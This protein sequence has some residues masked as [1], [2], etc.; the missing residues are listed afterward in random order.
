MWWIIAYAVQAGITIAICVREVAHPQR[1]LTWAVLNLLFPGI[2]LLAYLVLSQP[3][4]V[5]RRP[6]IVQTLRAADDSPLHPIPSGLSERFAAAIRQLAN[7]DPKPARVTLLQSGM[8]AFD[9]L[10][11]ML[12]DAKQTISIEYYIFRDDHVGRRILTHICEAA[13]RGVRVRFLRDG[14]GSKLSRRALRQLTQAGVEC[15]VFAP[16]RLPKLKLLNHRDHTKIVV[17]DGGQALVGGINVGDEYTGANPMIPGPWRD[18]D[19]I[20]EGEAASQVQAVFEMNFAASEPDRKAAT[21]KRAPRTA[22][23]KAVHL[24]QQLAFTGIEASADLA[25]VDGIVQKLKS[26]PALVQ[27]IESGPDSP[28]PKIRE[29]FFLA[30]TM[31]EKSICLTTPYFAPDV[32]LSMALQT[33][34]A[35]GVRVRLLVPKRADHRLIAWASWAYFQPLIEAGVEIYLYEHGVLHA[36]LLMIDGEISMVGAANFDLRSFGQNYEVMS[37]VYDLHV[38]SQL[39]AQFERD[40]ESTERLTMEMLHARNLFDHVRQQSARLLAPL[41]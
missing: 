7:D 41:L 16:L 28:R 25:P 33:A 10:A 22:K 37:V 31:A 20:I 40:L 19:M 36:K 8:A 2:G 23:R 1:A 35:R 26:L 29:A 12:A 11:Q 13:E 6:R 14:L 39:E 4:P 3:L 9:A 27:T 21:R 30:V 34:V 38:A 5:R 32:D 17:V 18:T 15:R 24:Q